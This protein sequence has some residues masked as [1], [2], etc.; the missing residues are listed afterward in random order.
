MRENEREREREREIPF[1]E[2]FDPVGVLFHR[3]RFD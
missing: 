2:F 1:D 3:F